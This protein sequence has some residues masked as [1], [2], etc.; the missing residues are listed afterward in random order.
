RVKVAG[1]VVL[2][3]PGRALFIQDEQHGLYVQTR[4]PG[5]LAPGDRVEVIGF[6]DKGEYTPVIQDAV[7]TKTGSG[8][9]PAQAQCLPDDALSG[10]QDSRLISIEG[11][12]LDRTHNSQEATLVV[13]RD[14]HIFSAHLQAADPRVALSQLQNGSRLR[15]AGVCRIEV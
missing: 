5:Q 6:P 9:E 15:L 1:T 7:W 10:L 4:Q 14:A 13:G 3:Q 8:P 12:L 11:T 2:Q